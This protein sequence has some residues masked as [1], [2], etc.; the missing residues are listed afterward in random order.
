MPL[1]LSPTQVAFNARANGKFNKPFKEQVDFLRKKLNVPSAHYDDIVQGAHDRMF[2]VAGAAKADLLTDLHNAVNKAAAEG[3]SIGYFRKQFQDIVQKNGWEGYTGSETK[4]G[5]DWRTRIIYNTNLSTSYSA[6]R[7][8]Q[9]TD[10]DFLK[11]RPNWTY[12]HN[13]A[14]Q[15]PRP[16]HKSWD[17]TTLPANS[18]WFQT[19]FTP[20]GYGC[21]CYITAERKNAEIKQPPDDGTYQFTD[22]YGVTHS[23]PKGIDYGFDY[24]PGASRNQDLR[25]FVQDKLVRYDPAI[26]RALSRDVNRYINANLTASKFADNVLGDKSIQEPAWLGFVAN[27]EQLVDISFADTTG[28]LI[29]LPSDAVRHIDRSHKRDGNGQRPVK[30]DDYDYVARILADGDLS[31]A[32]SA[33]SGAKRVLATLTIKNDTF[34][35]VFEVSGKNLRALSLITMSISTK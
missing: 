15:H 12:H 31:A 19:H 35:A 22:R 17:G 7:Y 1:I 26:S 27:P 3:K 21:Q 28:Y 16:I 30:P 20:N 9:L 11:V 4:A 2:M 33:P 10:P 6:G 25:V 13:D 29:L 32:K 24:T 23:I 5:R 8:A 34:R 14:V 18:G